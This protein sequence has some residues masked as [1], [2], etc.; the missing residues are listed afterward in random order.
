MEMAIVGDPS[1][2]QVRN[3]GRSKT[4]QIKVCILPIHAHVQHD[5]DPMF[6]DAANIWIMTMKKPS[7]K[8]NRCNEET[9]H[10]DI[11]I[12]RYFACTRAFK[13]CI[14]T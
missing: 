6:S 11:I 4:R 9:R 3:F 2:V 12:H 1:Y 8:R 7:G 5:K 13:Y 14:G 10:L